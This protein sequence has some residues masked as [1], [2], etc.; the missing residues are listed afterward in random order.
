MANESYKQFTKQAKSGI[1]GEA[2]F[3]M[4]M[5]DYALPHRIV[6]SK[7]IGIDYFCEWVFGDKPTGIL[8]AVQIKTFTEEN[9]SI[10]FIEV[11]ENWNGLEQFTIRH[12]LLKIND[13]TLQYW[14]GLGIPIYLFAIVQKNDGEGIDCFYRRYTP[15]LTSAS[16]SDDSGEYFEGFYKA[17]QGSSLIAFRDKI[18]RTQGFARDLFIDHVRCSYAKG[19]VTYMD[20]ESIGL[21]Q[22]QPNALF[23]DLFEDY[24]EQIRFAYE[25]TGNY[26]EVLRQKKS[27]K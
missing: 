23:A 27:R 24:E 16:N 5:T 9:V 8:F 19:L 3:E 25:K 21:N 4:L 26:L 20:P 2:F 1:K 17:N 15:L 22:F 12:S 13:E 11:N 18:K 14:K 7:D 10:K 6:G